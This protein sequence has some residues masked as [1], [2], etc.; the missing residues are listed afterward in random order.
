MTMYGH[1][2]VL[3]DTHSSDRETCQA[4]MGMIECSTLDVAE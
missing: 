1:S 3:L 4:V 2:T